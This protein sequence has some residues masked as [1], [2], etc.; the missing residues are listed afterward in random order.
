MMHWKTDGGGAGRAFAAMLA[1]LLAIAM[2]SPAIAVYAEDVA[3]EPSSSES[4]GPPAQPV[5]EEAQGFAAAPAAPEAEASAPVEPDVAAKPDA[6]T[7]PAPVLPKRAS[8]AAPAPE[9]MSATVYADAGSVTFEGWTRSPQAKWTTGDVKG[10]VEG[11]WVPYRLTITNK[12]NGP[13]AVPSMAFKMDHYWSQKNAIACDETR[14][15]RW[16]VQDGPSGTFSPTDH[17]KKIEGDAYLMTRLPEAPSFVI[18]KGKVGYVYFEGHLAVTW[19]WMAKAGIKG[20][21]GYTGSSAQARLYEWNGSTIG[22]KTV[23]M[24]VGREAAPTGRVYGLKFE[25]KNGNGQRETGEG[26]LAGFVFTLSYLDSTHPFSLTATSA[27]DGTFGFDALPPGDYRLS[28][29][30][31]AGWELT[32]D[33]SGVICVSSSGSVTGPEGSECTQSRPILVG[34]RRTG[35]TKTFSLALS[36]EMPAAAGY[37]VRYAV[38]A[39]TYELALAPS[40]APGVFTAQAVLPY[41]TTIAWWRFYAQ[42]GAEAVPLSPVLGP[43]TL[44]GPAT[45]S[46]RHDPGS[47]AGHKYIDTDGDGRG[48]AP[49]SGWLI[50]LFRSGVLYAQATTGE[51]GS[52]R[53]AGLIPGSYTVEEAE[54]SEYLRVWPEGPQLGPFQI[55]SGTA[56]EGAD[57]VNQQRPGSIEVYK[58]VSPTV[59]HAGDTL[60]YTIDVRNTGQIAV[61][62]TEVSDPMLYGGAN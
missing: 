12:T 37:F 11:E 20:A 50:K 15:W 25:D 22:E 9:A 53:F 17:D 44:T 3:A 56:I 23:S 62:L 57:F 48:D 6:P 59:A 26:P 42:A 38:G 27:A 13:I 55:G 19:E 24:P 36:G 45:N 39:A 32:T 60:A 5:D 14:G 61:L 54:Q 28:E 33:L 46:W 34:D 1:I 52:Y 41:G 35:V 51:D 7:A 4:T 49:G 47:I 10:Y 16:E 29:A 40:A 31:P 43:E 2:I 18:P 30:V 8:A 21:S 58:S